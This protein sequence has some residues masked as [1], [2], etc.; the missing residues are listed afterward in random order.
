MGLIVALGSKSETTSP[1]GVRWSSFSP[2]LL[3]Q[4]FQM[5]KAGYV[6]N[7]LK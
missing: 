6:A 2:K 4:D 1:L 3:H 5:G 7:A